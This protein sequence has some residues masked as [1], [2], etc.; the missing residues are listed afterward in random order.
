MP[1]K[2]VVGRNWKGAQAARLRDTVR[3]VLCSGVVFPD[4]DLCLFSIG[5][6]WIWMQFSNTDFSG[7]EIDDL[8]HVGDTSA[9]VQ[10][11][12]DDVLILGGG[13]RVPAGVS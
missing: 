5:D 2:S 12:L 3:G 10:S 4:A 8:C 7:F 13:Q 9:K 11:A 1:V 6:R